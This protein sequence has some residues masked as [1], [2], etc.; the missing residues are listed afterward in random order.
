[1]RYVRI[2]NGKTVGKVRFVKF[3]RHHDVTWR[4]KLYK[5]AYISTAKTAG[6]IEKLITGVKSMGH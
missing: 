3:L 5:S 1:M 4:R 2:C 6:Y